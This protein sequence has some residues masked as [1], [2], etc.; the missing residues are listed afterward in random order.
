MK[1]EQIIEVLNKYVRKIDDSDYHDEAIF[2]ELGCFASI[3][4]ELESLQEDGKPVELLGT[5]VPDITKAYISPSKEQISFFVDGGWKFFNR[6]DLQEDKPRMSKE[7]QCQN[8]IDKVGE[9][10]T[11]DKRSFEQAEADKKQPT[12]EEIQKWINEQFIPYD[13]DSP[14][15]ESEVAKSY[16]KDGMRIMAKAMRDGL[17]PHKD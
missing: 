5:N 3:A 8:I 1:K 17:I 10:W 9:S 16:V 2:D 14:L 11:P 15:P 4:S 13:P 6:T 12:D 7:Q